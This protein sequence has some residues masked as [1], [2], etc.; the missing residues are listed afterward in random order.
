[1]VLGVPILKHFRA[2]IFP[3][4]KTPSPSKYL[5]RLFIK[6]MLFKSSKTDFVGPYENCPGS[7][8][9]SQSSLGK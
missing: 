2:C 8:V 4:I 5:I 9:S 3:L 7:K 1:M 6:H